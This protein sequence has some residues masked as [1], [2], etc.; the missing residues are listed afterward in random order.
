VRG[1]RQACVFRLSSA[2]QAAAMA[3]GTGPRKPI[4]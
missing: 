1:L 4:E 3:H 2:M